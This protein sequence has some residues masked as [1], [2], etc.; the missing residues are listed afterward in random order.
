MKHGEEE[1][2]HFLRPY[3]NLGV[4]LLLGVGAGLAMAPRAAR[5]QSSELGQL[6]GQEPSPLLGH[7]STSQ[8]YLG[9]DVA[10]VDQEKRRLSSSRKCAARSLR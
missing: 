10:D 1:M 3:H 7:S 8:G 4:A 9:V 6:M 5:A 2:K